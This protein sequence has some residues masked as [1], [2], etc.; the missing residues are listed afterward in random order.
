MDERRSRFSIRYSGQRRG[1]VGVL[2]WQACGESTKAANQ[3]HSS[4]RVFPHTPGP[5]SK[6]F[7]TTATEN[8]LHSNQPAPAQEGG[9]TGLAPQAILILCCP[10]YYFTSNGQGIR[11]GCAQEPIIWSSVISIFI[12]RLHFETH[13]SLNHLTVCRPSHSHSHSHSFVIGHSTSRPFTKLYHCCDSHLTGLRLLLLLLL[14]LS[15]LLLL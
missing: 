13:T 9:D 3:S 15:L 5:A 7:C 1:C 10:V 12:T 14:L 4:T 11:P 6:F 8:P 2:S